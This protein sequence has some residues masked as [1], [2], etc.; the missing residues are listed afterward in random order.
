[1]HIASISLIHNFGSPFVNEKKW[2]FR[3][4]PLANKKKSFVY[5]SYV[6]IHIHENVWLRQDVFSEWDFFAFVSMIHIHNGYFKKSVSSVI[7]FWMKRVINPQCN[8]VMQ[9]I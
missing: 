7:H 8:A 9:Q 3:F 2:N 6:T 5:K 4:L 1:M